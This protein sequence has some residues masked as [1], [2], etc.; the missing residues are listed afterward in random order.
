MVKYATALRLG[1]A[2]TKS[3][4]RRF[5]RSN[6]HPT[7]GALAEIDKAVRTILLYDYL[8]QEGLNVIENWNSA[9]TPLS[10]LGTD[11]RSPD[12][13]HYVASL[14]SLHSEM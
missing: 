4:L 11:R 10:S 8:H 5:A 12:R 1:T 2:E 6:V 13:C 14:V 3:I 9:K 7:Y